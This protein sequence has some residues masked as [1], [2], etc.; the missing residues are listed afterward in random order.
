MHQI[1]FSLT[2]YSRTHISINHSQRFKVY[3]VTQGQHFR[4]NGARDK[5]KYVTLH[6]GENQ[7]HFPHHIFVKFSVPREFLNPGPISSTSILRYFVRNKRRE[8]TANPTERLRQKAQLLHLKDCHYH[9][10][11]LLWRSLLFG[12]NILPLEAN[13]QCIH[14]TRVHKQFVTRVHILFYFLHEIMNP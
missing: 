10:I 7:I 6:N 14:N 12:R 9:V 5:R 3:R 1:I 4:K 8:T 11:M 13:L 2:L